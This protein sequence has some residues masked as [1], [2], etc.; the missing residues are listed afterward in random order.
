M[1]KPGLDTIAGVSLVELMIAGFLLLIIAL[2]TA[3]VFMSSSNTMVKSWDES[4]A[5][6]RCQELLEEIKSL[7]YEYIHQALAD[8]AQVD[9]F[10]MNIINPILVPK[11]ATT[12][13]V[14]VTLV[15]HTQDDFIAHGY[16]NP[17]GISF[18]WED[19]GT[20]T[21]VSN[22]IRITGG[23][24][25]G[26]ITLKMYE[27]VDYRRYGTL[28]GVNIGIVQRV[29]LYPEAGEQVDGKDI[30]GTITLR[31]VFYDDP[32]DML[33]PGDIFPADYKVGSVTITW[34]KFS[35]GSVI[36]RSLTAIIAP[37]PDTYYE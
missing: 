23:I 13:N 6:A 18:I 25:D 28:T 12:V 2:F 31:F 10:H 22:K 34:C 15:A 30:T 3:S 7:P 5:I 35:G 16:N 17:E 33:A 9:H 37:K 4:V 8:T 14:D 36:S 20:T 27:P 32:N 19:M 29:M 26:V 1:R 21:Q 24:G 11:N